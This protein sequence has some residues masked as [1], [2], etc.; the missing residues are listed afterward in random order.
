[1]PDDYCIAKLDFTNAFNSLHRDVMLKTMLE[2]VPGIYKICHLAFDRPSVLSYNG[3]T[4]FSSEGPQQGDPLGPSLFC[5][6]IHPLLSSLTSILRLGYMDDVTVGGPESQ[7][8][9]DVET[10]RSKGGEI[11]V[12][13]N[14]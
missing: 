12:H 8:A 7:I 14:N 6:T 10:I 2:R 4:V 11:G 9:S 13:L 5:A 3:R 1:M